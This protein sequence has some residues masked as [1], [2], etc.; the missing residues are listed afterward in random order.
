MSRTLE[1]DLLTIV[2]N[3]GTENDATSLVR[4]LAKRIQNG[5]I[6]L[7]DLVWCDTYSKA[8]E[9]LCSECRST[10]VKGA[11]YYNA[12]LAER[13][14]GSRFDEGDSA[15]WVYVKGV[16][17][18]CLKQTSCHSKESEL[19]EFILD[20]DTMVLKL[21]TKKIEPIY[22]ALEWNIDYASGKAS[23]SLIGDSFN[24]IGC[25]PKER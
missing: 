3:G 23:R 25:S 17:D 22:K 18:G 6:P 8:L 24:I 13:Y 20:Y 1:R 14:N 5:E 15:K 16:P 10:G 12:H 11:R 4:P 21:I 19:D 7:K 9:Q 2:C